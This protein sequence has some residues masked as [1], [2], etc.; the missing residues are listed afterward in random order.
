MD[1]F[2]FVTHPRHEREFAQDFFPVRFMP[3]FLV[4]KIMRIC[5]PYRL[6]DVKGAASKY[7]RISGWVISSPL[8][9]DMIAQNESR[10]IKKVLSACRQARKLG[11]RIIGLGNELCLVEGLAE[12]ISQSLAIPV[13]TGNSYRI[14][15]VIEGL[16]MATAARGVELDNTNVII[17]GAASNIGRICACVLA[18]EVREITLIDDNKNKTQKIAGQIL[19]DS[20]LIAKVAQV[21]EPSLKDADVVIIA[22]Y[23]SIEID[24]CWFKSGAIV[25][26]VLS[27][28]QG[29][30]KAAA[31]RNDILVIEKI[32]TTISGGAD[33]NK[34]MRLPKDLIDS[35]MAEVMI[36][37]LEKQYHSSISNTAIQV[38]QIYDIR[39]LAEKHG[40]KVSGFLTKS[41]QE[42]IKNS[43]SGKIIVSGTA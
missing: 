25:I 31:K 24:S 32:Y 14:S 43:I 7:N 28:G 4:S 30:A 40:F 42:G 27:M 13:T 39:K 1:S 34:N 3:N 19:Y 22:D 8:T 29:V 37:T 9:S 33:F 5:P 11:A 41:N 21:L 38:R 10:T 6:F 35:D 23:N 2:A 16:K 36:L 26:D 12:A 15:A 20:G 17:I 18:S